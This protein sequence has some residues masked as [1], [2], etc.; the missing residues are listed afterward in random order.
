[1]ISS[2]TALGLMFCAVL[3]FG[4]VP[5]SAAD[6]DGPKLKWDV[7]LWGK[8]RPGTAL[9]DALAARIEEA[10]GGNWRFVLHYGEAVSKAGR[11]STGSPSTPSRQRWW[12]T[13]TTP[14][15]TRP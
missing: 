5:A 2:K 15:R 4:S 14:R 13:S 11:T 3:A 6:V 8:P 12:P 7:S 10:T 1:M 9:V